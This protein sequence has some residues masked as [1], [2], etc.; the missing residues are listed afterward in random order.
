M[1]QAEKNR[2]KEDLPRER[3]RE[4]T[5]QKWSGNQIKQKKILF[6]PDL[7]HLID[8][9]KVVFI[10]DFGAWVLRA[11]R[12]ALIVGE[13]GE[14]GKAGEDQGEDQGEE[15]SAVSS[16]EEQTSVFFCFRGQKDLNPPAIINSGRIN[17]Y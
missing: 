15:D 16:E 3:E 8:V 11:E 13:E 17:R 1:R 12:E 2:R 10:V 6:S 5:L 14:A 7:R 4:S 9:K